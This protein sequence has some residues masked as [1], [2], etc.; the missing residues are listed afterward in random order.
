MSLNTV[1]VLE[2]SITNNSKKE[3]LEEISKYLEN[4]PEKRG[5]PFVIVTPNTEQIVYSRQDSHFQDIV[6]RADV[7]LPDSVG[8]VWASRKLNKKGVDRPMPG[9][10]FMESLVASAAVRH[11]PIALIGGRG[12]LAIDTLDCLRQKYSGLTGWAESGPEVKVRN[13][14]LLMPD[15]DETASVHIIADHIL[16]SGIQMVF[17]AMGPPKQ[18]YFIDA[19]SHALSLRGAKATKQSV[20]KP[21]VLMAVGGSFDIISGKLKRAPKFMRSLKLEWLW[22]LILQPWRIGRQLALLKFIWLVF[23]ANPA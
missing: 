6:N 4:T 18:E 1:K 13:S 14:E 9:V 19:L 15:G 8:V 5:K 23:R 17:I 2:I 22:R 11:V 16:A 21:I 20:M 10:D 3:I 12:K 7:S